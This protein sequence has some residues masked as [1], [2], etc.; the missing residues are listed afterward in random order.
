MP[1]QLQ[2][3]GGTSTEHNSFTGVAREVT[4]DTTK[5]TLVVHDGSTAGG[6]PLMKESG[7]SGDVTFNSITVGKG[8]N[9]VAGNTVVGETA[10]DAAVTGANNTAIGKNALTALTSATG[11]VAVGQGALDANTTG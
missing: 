3:R 5:K 7:H 6:T 2:L 10:L 8:A 9:S 4:V 1:D 11:V